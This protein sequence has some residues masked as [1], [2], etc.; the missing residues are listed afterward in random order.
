MENYFV[1]NLETKKLEL[2]F[3]RERYAELTD[4]Q[5]QEIKS[6][7]L[8]GRNS[9]CWI[10]R[11]KE[12]NLYWP[13]RVA[14][15]LGLEDAGKAGERLSF[16]EQMERKA[17]RAERRADRYDGHADAAEGRAEALQKPI[18]DMHGDIAFFTQPNINTSAG[19][20]FTRRRERMF[21][22]YEAGFNELRKSAYWQDRAAT[23][24][25]T[26]A[27][28]EL[29]DKG[30]VCR[31]IAERESSIRKVEKRIVE[32][33]D[34]LYKME[35]GEKPVDRYGYPIRIT[36]DG[37]KNQ[38]EADLDRMEVLLDELGYYQEC[39]DKLGGVQFGKNDLKKGD[40]IYISRWKE[41]VRFLR[42]GPK[43]FTYEFTLSHMTYAD[44]SPMQGQA[45]YAEITGRVEEV[46]K[47]GAEDPAI[48]LDEFADHHA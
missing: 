48:T 13:R 20:A 29:K 6:S 1:L 16:A 4:K 42:G 12:P 32:Y 15:S 37:A 22:A 14:E 28:S 5:K 25:A 40:L 31:R 26:A 18:H 21:A 3:T 30:F 43:N 27:Q 8:W 46:E 41:P 23:A 10:S 36:E 2:H 11:A 47:T 33:E 7:F 44:G 9:G 17:E 24:R 35:A 34:Y 39:L 38:L 19:R 45:A